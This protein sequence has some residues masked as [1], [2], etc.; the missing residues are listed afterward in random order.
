MSFYNDKNNELLYTY[1]HTL[2]RYQTPD[3]IALD[4]LYT[5]KL[6]VHTV[7]SYSEGN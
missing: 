4:P 2:N 7:P 1:M 5:Y 6:V 3:T